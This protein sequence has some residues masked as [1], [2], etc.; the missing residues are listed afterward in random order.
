MPEVF[1]GEPEL[2]DGASTDVA[3][4]AGEGAGAG[5]GAGAAVSSLIFTHCE[6]FGIIANL[7]MELV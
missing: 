5:A 4:A 7:Y 6:N 2:L 3:G 1:S